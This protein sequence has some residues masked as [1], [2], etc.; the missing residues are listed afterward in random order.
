MAAYR[1][2]TWSRDRVVS[3]QMTGAGDV[4]LRQPAGDAG[5]GLVE[6]HHLGL[7]QQ[8][9]Y[10]LLKRRQ[11]RVDKA[12]RQWRT[13]QFREF[14]RGPQGMHVLSGYVH[15]VRSGRGRDVTMT[16]NFSRPVLDHLRAKF[17]Q[18]K[19]LREQEP[20]RLALWVQHVRKS[21][22]RCQEILND[23]VVRISYLKQGAAIMSLFVPRRMDSDLTP[24]SRNRFA[25]RRT[26]RRR[27]RRFQTIPS[28]SCASTPRSPPTVPGPQ[29]SW[30]PRNPSTLG[31]AS[32]FS[33][34]CAQSK[35]NIGGLFKN[36][37]WTS[38]PCWETTARKGHD[39]RIILNKMIEYYYL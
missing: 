30:Q 18:I 29:G 21:V 31:S 27:L 32:T 26:H 20:G 3:G 6:V 13:K 33:Q 9:H 10:A 22:M 38:F 4:E 35:L 16:A 15:S 34:V 36:Q 37:M 19:N 11:S 7:L 23:R 1:E 17:W 2:C 8:R 12:L 14:L 28:S 5:A 39:L 25:E 24:R